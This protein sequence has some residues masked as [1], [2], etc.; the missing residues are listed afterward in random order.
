M[1][2]LPTYLL[3]YLVAIGFL[4]AYRIDRATHQD[5]LRRLADAAALAEVAEEA[6]APIAP[7]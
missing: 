2:Y 5:N 7:H 6:G 3:P 4:S 1:L